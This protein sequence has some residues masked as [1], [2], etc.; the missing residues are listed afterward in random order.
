MDN[1]KAQN[2]IALLNECFLNYSTNP[3]ENINRLVK[4]CGEMLGATCA[5]YNN[6]QKNLLCSLGQWNSPPDYTPE[7][8]AE[9]HICY[10]V[11][12]AGEDKPVIINNLPHTKYFFTDPNVKAYNLKTYIGVAVKWRNEFVGSLCVVY[13]DDFT[14]QKDDLNLLNLIASAISIEE[15]R[16]RTE[17]EIVDKEQIY[18]HLIFISFSNIWYA[19]KKTFRI[20]L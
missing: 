10:D 9:G 5:L 14:P 8:N 2:R 4:F 7:N 15:D 12:R 11:I 16:K 3:D 18:R 6:L 1:L 20:L 17:I 19:C 13:R